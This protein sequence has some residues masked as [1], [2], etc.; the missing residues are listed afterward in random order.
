LKG[1]GAG[2]AGGAGGFEQGIKIRQYREEQT[3][4][5]I[6]AGSMYIDRLVCDK[7]TG[8]LFTAALS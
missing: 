3:E 5:D 2:G 1:T 8:F 6:V 4:S 7:D